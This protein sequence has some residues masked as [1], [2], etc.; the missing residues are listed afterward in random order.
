MAGDIQ[1]AEYQLK[2]LFF[3]LKPH[4]KFLKIKKKFFFFQFYGEIVNSK[5]V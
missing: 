2:L 3:T 5:T 1:L 4:I